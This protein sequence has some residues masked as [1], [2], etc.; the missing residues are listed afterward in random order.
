MITESVT[1]DVANEIGWIP[2]LKDTLRF[3]YPYNL[4]LPFII[5]EKRQRRF[6]LLNAHATNY[7]EAA[8]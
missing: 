1:V 7:D 5:K 8:I 2:I 4:K 6:L 3:M